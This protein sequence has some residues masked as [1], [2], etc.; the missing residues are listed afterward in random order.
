MSSCPA[1]ARSQGQDCGPP[2][3]GG[4]LDWRPEGFQATGLTRPTSWDCRE[5]TFPSQ[6]AWCRPHRCPGGR[7]SRADRAFL[8][9]LV[10][11]DEKVTT[12]RSGWLLPGCDLWLLSLSPSGAV[13]TL[14]V[15]QHLF[16][17][18]K[19]E[20]TGRAPGSVRGSGQRA[21]GWQSGVCVGRGAQCR[22]LPS[23]LLSLSLLDQP[24]S[25]A[26]RETLPAKPGP[27]VHGAS[28]DHRPFQCVCPVPST[29]L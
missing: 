27:T 20:R 9:L 29:R 13:S 4:T 25:K 11:G 14:R 26:H 19:L 22:R 23:P 28:P 6:C 18:G 10:G 5:P 12:D 3:T 15:L 7:G 16:S 2:G 8:W 1:Q 24:F 17:P 21:E